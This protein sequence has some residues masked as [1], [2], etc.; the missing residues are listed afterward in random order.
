M[1]QLLFIIAS[2]FFLNGCNSPS[3]PQDERENQIARINKL[4]SRILGNDVFSRDTA[5]MLVELQSV[6]AENYPQ[7][8]LAA[9]YL[10]KAADIAKGAD[11]P[12]LAIKLW[13][14]VHRQYPD[15]KAAPESLFLQAFTFEN[16]IKD[17]NNAKV[18][19]ETFINRYPNHELAQVARLALE[20]I[21]QSPDE[22]LKKFENKQ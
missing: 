19:Y 11:K 18:Y 22:L 10:F 15:F 2:F 9:I 12:G 20:N 3:N 13:G 6:F 14:K 8:S 7:D 4:E 21:G 16:Q 1:Y 5:L 17:L